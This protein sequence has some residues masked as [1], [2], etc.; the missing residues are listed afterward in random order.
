[1]GVK[2]KGPA[3]ARLA[4]RL[5]V[6]QEGS[7]WACAGFKFPC[8]S[9]GAAAKRAATDL[10]ASAGLPVPASKAGAH[11]AERSVEAFPVPAR[12]AHGGAERGCPAA[13]HGGRAGP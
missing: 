12:P 9:P 3:A 5:S 4:S 10:Q 2:A 7:G 13:D 6:R 8:W 1:M 11:R